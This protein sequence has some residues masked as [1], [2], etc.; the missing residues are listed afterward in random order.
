MNCNTSPHFVGI[1]QLKAK[2]KWQLDIFESWAQRGEWMQMHNAHYDWWMFPIDSPSA[3]GLTYT[4]YEG[5]IA[6]L[7]LDAQYLRNYLRGAQLVAAGWGWDLDAADHLPNPAADQRWQHWPVRLFKAA[8]S[9]QLFAYSD[10]FES[11]KKYALELM[12]AGEVMEYNG[13]DLSW[14]FTTGIDPRRK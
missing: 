11:L 4:V 12:G 14:L 10:Y 7:K 2:L 13:H 8:R 9:L 1:A 3:Y 6:E 5:D